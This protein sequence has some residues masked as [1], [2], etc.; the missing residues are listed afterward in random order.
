MAGR[1]R[2][3]D[4]AV[5]DASPGASCQGNRPLGEMMDRNG[6]IL[7]GGMS[8]WG[9]LLSGGALGMSRTQRGHCFLVDWRESHRRDV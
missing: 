4:T 3:T 8:Q 6:V 1:W 2:Y 7:A 9:I 5:G